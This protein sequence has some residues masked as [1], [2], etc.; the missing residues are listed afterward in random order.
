VFGST[1][2]PP[3][4]VSALDGDFARSV[5]AHA[6]VLQHVARTPH[7]LSLT[8]SVCLVA[9][10]QVVLPGRIAAHRHYEQ[11]ALIV[12]QSAFFRV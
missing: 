9:V 7:S 12:W 2:S 5:H 4:Q 3:D 1:G 10:K 6:G 8:D 11:P